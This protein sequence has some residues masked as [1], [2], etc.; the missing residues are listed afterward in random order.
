M[1]TFTK[2]N[3]V[4]PNASRALEEYRQ[5]LVW[6]LEHCYGLTLNDTPYHE[7]LAITQQIECGVTVRET[8]N[9]LVQ[10]YDLV[11]IDRSGFSLLVQDPMLSSGDMLRARSALGLRSPINS[12]LI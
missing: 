9:E 3:N 7:T 5:L 12:R 10:K 8:I 1:K 2:M 6:L 4:I 11:R